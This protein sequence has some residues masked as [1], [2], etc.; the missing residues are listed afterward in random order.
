MTWYRYG[1]KIYL[2][3]NLFSYRCNYLQ[4]YISSQTQKFFAQLFIS[5]LSITYLIVDM[6]QKLQAKDIKL[7]L[8]SLIAE[9]E[10]VNN[11]LASRLN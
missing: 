6:N 3:T 11:V 10:T 2:F 1:A 9:A 4:S 8:D 7:R 5:Y